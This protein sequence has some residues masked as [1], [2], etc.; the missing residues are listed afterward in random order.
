MSKMKS[1][2][3]MKMLKK[4]KSKARDDMHEE[5][6]KELTKGMQK[7]TIA[8]DSKEGL[9]KGLDKAKEILKGRMEMMDDDKDE[10]SCGG[11]EK[12][13]DGGCGSV[14]KEVLKKM[15]SRK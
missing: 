7:I 12:Y 6:M 9:E 11:T 14:K 4:L 3:R 8:S 1:K 15:K 10:Y 5:P 2:A 13:A